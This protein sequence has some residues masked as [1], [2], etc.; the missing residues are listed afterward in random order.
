MSYIAA[1][2]AIPSFSFN[3]VI[4]SRWTLKIVSAATT[5]DTTLTF[6]R[7][8]VHTPTQ[9]QYIPHHT[10]NHQRYLTHTFS[11]IVWM[12]CC[13]IFLISSRLTSGARYA[14]TIPFSRSFPSSPF[15]APHSLTRLSRLCVR[16]Q[17]T[18]ILL[19]YLACIR[20]L[21]T[22]IVTL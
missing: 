11:I 14:C 2:I 9:P 6:F 20:M 21:H 15:V 4:F 16:N 10:Y 3:P 17:G 1:I 7:S 13:T 18:F 22:C 12:V 19:S 8:L 5:P